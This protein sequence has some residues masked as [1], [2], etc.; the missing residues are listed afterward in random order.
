MLSVKS[1]Q[2]TQEK[3]RKYQK[4]YNQRPEVKERRKE[5]AKK[6]LQRPEIKE[7]RKKHEQMPEFKERRKEWAKK[8][9]NELGGNFDIEKF[10][11]KAFLNEK[12][13]RI[14]MHL[15]STSR[16]R[17][18]IGKLNHTFEFKKGETIYSE[19]SY[20]FSKEQ[21]KEMAKTSGFE[22][23]HSWYDSKTWFSLNL[24]KPV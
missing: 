7:H 3:I 8:Y 22:V 24:F 19:D 18:K 20:K 10:R 1:S 14:E 9:L 13:S 12:M 6:Y 5:W 23:K 17:V 4:E 16:Q 21:I 11:H 15:E 2:E